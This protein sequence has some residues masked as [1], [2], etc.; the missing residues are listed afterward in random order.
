MDVQPAIP[1]RVAW[2]KRLHAMTDKRTSD[3]DSA[4]SNQHRASKKLREINKG[5][6]LDQTNMASQTPILHQTEHEQSQNMTLA[7]WSL[8]SALLIYELQAS[9]KA[10]CSSL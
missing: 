9:S 10:N 3:T 5:C 4:C 2:C 6:P 7:A 8:A 1:A